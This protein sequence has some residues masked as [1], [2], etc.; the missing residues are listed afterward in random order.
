MS[1]PDE[2]RAE[3]LELLAD[4]VLAR[5]LAGSSLRPLA[6]AARTSDRMLLYYFKDKDELIAAV[7]AHIRLRLAAELERVLPRTRMESRALGETLF[8]LATGEALWPYMRLWLEIAALAARG[9]PV[10]R[11]V[12]KAIAL[13]LI[14]RVAERLEDSAPNAQALRL[15]VG[16]EGRLALHSVGVGG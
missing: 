2:K 13:G 15:V 6:A 5:G 9:D 12:G 4:H 8:D 3:L 1:A 10:C 7:L 16:L 14:G 11:T